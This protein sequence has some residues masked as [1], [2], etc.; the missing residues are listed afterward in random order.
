VLLAGGYDD[1]NDGQ[2]ASAELYDPAANTWRPTGSMAAGRASHTAILMDSGAVLVAGGVR[3]GVGPLTSA[4]E[5]KPATGRWVPEPS[6]GCARSVHSAIRM[7][8]GS[9]LVVGACGTGSGAEVFR[10]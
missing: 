3:D 5:Y 7:H 9:I 4:E 6:I 8:D 1:A 2:V 10:P